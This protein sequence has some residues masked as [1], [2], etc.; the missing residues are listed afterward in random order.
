M[1]GTD[2]G[3]LAEDPGNNIIRGNHSRLRGHSASDGSN[4]PGDGKVT[5]FYYYLHTDVVKSSLQR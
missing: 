4:L 1:I 3:L 5:L 2:D